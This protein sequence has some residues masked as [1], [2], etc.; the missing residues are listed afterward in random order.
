MTGA[1]RSLLGVV[2]PLFV[3]LQWWRWRKRS[4][5][6]PETRV[7]EL[8]FLAAATAYSFASPWREHLDW[9]DAL[10]LVALFVV[11]FIRAARHEGEEPGIVGLAA[12]IAAFPAIG[13]RIV[14]V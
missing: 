14:V 12:V 9:L 2:W 5:V 6:L 8:P 4:L 7:V 11:Y 10:V 1:N 13:R 3:L